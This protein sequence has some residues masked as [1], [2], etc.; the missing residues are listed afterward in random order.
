MSIRE[1]SARPRTQR[2]QDRF[3]GQASSD[4]A[5]GERHWHGGAPARRMTHRAVQPTDPEI[6]AE[7]L[8]QARVGHEDHERAE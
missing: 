2:Q 7:T 6:G 5:P 8:R 1:P 4:P 3:A